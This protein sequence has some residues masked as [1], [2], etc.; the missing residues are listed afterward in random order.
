[1][2]TI[3]NITIIIIGA[4]ALMIAYTIKPL[5]K[6]KYSVRRKTTEMRNNLINKLDCTI[7][8]LKEMH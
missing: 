6:I 3:K 2:K 1:M 5:L 8:D 7:C 4:I